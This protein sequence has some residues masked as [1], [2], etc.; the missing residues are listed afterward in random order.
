[1]QY[2]VQGAAQYGMEPNEF[3]KV[4]SENNQI[5][6]MVGEVAR[7]KAL[8][9]VLGKAVVKD[10]DGRAVDLSEFVAIPGDDSADE[11]AA[12]DADAATG[13]EEVPDEKPAKARKRSSK[14]SA[15][16]TADEA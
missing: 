4:L 6:A 2:L 13:T 1:M 14:K 16:A 3:V 5:P 11:S 9:I 12:E 15:E 10:S 7:N 8:A